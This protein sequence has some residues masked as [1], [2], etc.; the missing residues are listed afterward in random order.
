MTA[1]SRS[2]LLAG[3][4]SALVPGAGQWYAGERRRAVWFTVPF[5]AAVLIG[6]WLALRGKVGLLVLLVQPV[7]IVS[8]TVLNAA[9][10]VLR[11][12]AAVGV[13]HRRG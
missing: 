5:V 7:W 6:V 10:A 8:L 2:P 1:T 12:A 11:M 9:V 4:L 13:P 3:I